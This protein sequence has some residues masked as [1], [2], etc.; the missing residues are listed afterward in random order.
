MISCISPTDIHYDETI[1]TLRY[2]SRAKNI[3]NKPKINEDP[4]DARLRQYQNEILYLKRML[5]ESQQI[6]NKNNDPNKI[7]KSPLKIIQHTNMNSTKNVQIIDLGRNC[8]ASFKTNNSI[9]TKP[10]FPL[11]QSKEE[12]QLQARSRIDLIKRSLIGGE[13]IHD[14]ELKEKH[15]ARKYAAQRHLSAIAIA[16][17]RVKCEDRDLLQGHY[18]TITQEIDIKNDY[19]RKCKEKIKMLEM[20]VSDLNSEFQ[21]DREDYLDEIRNLGRQV[22]FHQQL[23][24]KFSSNPGKFDRNW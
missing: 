20:E 21:L 11:I 9:L 17:S 3:S 14:F 4:K 13:R 24:L 22:K 19:I 5:Q 6:I 18:A 16:L 1:S 2:A 15:M 23:F 10:N 12:V 7:I 8:K